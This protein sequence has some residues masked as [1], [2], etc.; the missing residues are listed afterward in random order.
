MLWQPP[1][2]PKYHQMSDEQLISAITARRKQLGDQLV[3]LGHHYQQDEVIQFADFTGD[4]F[5][6]SQLAAERVR[7]TGAKYVI[8]C[9]VHFMAESADILAPE[10]VS[11]ILPDLG[12]GCSMADM[13][14]HEQVLDAWD[15]IHSHQATKPPSHQG[16]DDQNASLGGS[17]A[18]GSMA[19]RVIPICYMNSTAAIK[20]FCGE[21]GGA[22]CTSSNCQRIF[23]W[24][25]AGGTQPLQEGEQ[26]KILFMPDQHLGRNTAAMM[27]YDVTTQTAVWDPHDPDGRGG[28]DEQTIND[29]TFLL[30]KG[31]CSVH[32]LF[33]PEHVDQVRAEWPDVHVMCHPECA[34]EVCQKADSTGSTEQ[35]IAAVDKAQPGSRW[36]IGT[37]VHLVN[38]V[39]QQARK[40]DVN[41]RILSQCQCLCTTMYRIDLPHLLWVL[42][43]LAAGRVVNQI[44]VEPAISHW[45][46]EA[47]GRMLQ[48]TAAAK[49]QTSP[50]VPVD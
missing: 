30:W 50:S 2:A 48:I 25:L 38:R 17:V 45:A 33:R 15:A 6:L 21:H 32:K 3:I 26:I 24:A 41:V 5:K 39:A 13:A 19:F 9:G 35:I 4:S 40:R 43:E 37:E 47:L 14:D 36:A 16:G 20:A 44:K 22:V 28:L 8:F 18:G 34:Y 31:H 46:N 49:A 42:D 12:A 11:V 27:G 7:Q 29:A 23:E 10:D 1:L